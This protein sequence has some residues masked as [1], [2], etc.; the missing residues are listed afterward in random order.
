MGLSTTRVILPLIQVDHG[1]PLN[2]G[3]WFFWFHNDWLQI[4]FEQGMVGL[5]AAIIA[6][7]GAMK[8]GNRFIKTSIIAY[9]CAMLTNWPMH[10]PVCVL[11]G[12][13]LMKGAYETT[14][15]FS[16][17]G[18]ES[19]NVDVCEHHCS[20]TSRLLKSHERLY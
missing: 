16:T 4:L 11:L 13:V 17:R 1:T 18:R 14:E 15:E 3:P 20:L 6:F 9:A 10:S 8:C 5:C 19:R 12:F 2:E 7:Y